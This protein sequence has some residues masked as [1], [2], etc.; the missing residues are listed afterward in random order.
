MSPLT[1]SAAIGAET[2]FTFTDSAGRHGDF[3]IHFGFVGGGLLPGDGM[4]AQL[5]ALLIGRGIQ[6][7]FNLCRSA[8]YK[9]PAPG[10]R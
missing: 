1:P 8:W 2:V 4:S 7:D 9:R 3:K 6:V 10:G 5:N